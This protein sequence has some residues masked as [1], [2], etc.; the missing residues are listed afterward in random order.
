[1]LPW[2]LAP[3]SPYP[4]CLRQAAVVS[5]LTGG[6]GYR[7]AA[8]G[9]GVAWQLLWSWVDTLAKEA[10][11][12]LGALAGFALRHPELF[13]GGPLLPSTQDL[14]ALGPRARSPAKREA[15][16]ALGVSL[17]LAY[18]LWQAGSNLKL[19]WGSPDPAE[20]LSFLAWLGRPPA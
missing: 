13:A 9:L 10:K 14:D 6:D 8:A 15:L 20:V 19:A 18:A 3:R 5:L 7:V 12:A 1:M 17:V 16:C 11:A 4:W 2:F